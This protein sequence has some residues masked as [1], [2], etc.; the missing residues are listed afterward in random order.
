MDFNIDALYDYKNGELIPSN[1]KKQFNITEPEI[2]FS[3]LT[4]WNTGAATSFKFTRLYHNGT[5]NALET[6][7]IEC[8][9]NKL[10]TLYFNRKW[11][12]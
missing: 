2:V 10:D 12:E 3:T 1:L 5:A 6:A 7:I 11:L 9:E 8:F 4:N